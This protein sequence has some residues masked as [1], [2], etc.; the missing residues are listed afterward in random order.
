MSLCIIMTS[1]QMGS[2]DLIAYLTLPAVKA[3]DEGY[4][5]TKVGLPCRCLA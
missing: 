1:K 3:A 5:W 4:L 2:S